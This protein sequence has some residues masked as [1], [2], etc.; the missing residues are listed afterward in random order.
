[1]DFRLG[2]GLLQ[3]KFKHLKQIHT[4]TNPPQDALY[5]INPTSTMTP[6]LPSMGLLPDT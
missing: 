5:L 4:S 6:Y 2:I 3:Y 1:M